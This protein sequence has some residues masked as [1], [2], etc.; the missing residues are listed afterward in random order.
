MK[1][2]IA[3]D[4]ATS[5]K[6]LRLTLA[7]GGHEVVEAADGQEALEKLDS[8]P[9]DAV[10]SDI[11]MPRMDGYRFCYEARRKA[12][13]HDLPIIIYSATYTSPGEETV[14]LNMGADRFLRKPAPAAV[15]LSALS[16]VTG[17]PRV[18]ARSQAPASDLQVLKQY[19]ERLVQK[20]E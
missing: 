17:R 11:L 8:S 1:V 7:A 9:V 3:D 6:L 19:S 14:A 2:L 18:A 20:L 13:L 12:S 15:I 16:D 5:R 4:N 10:I